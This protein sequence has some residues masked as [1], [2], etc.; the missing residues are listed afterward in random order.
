MRFHILQDAT[1]LIRISTRAY[2]SDKVIYTAPTMRRAEI[3]AQFLT[4]S[5]AAY[6]VNSCAPRAVDRLGREITIPVSA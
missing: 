6:T 2:K 5:K 1:G 4:G 3:Y